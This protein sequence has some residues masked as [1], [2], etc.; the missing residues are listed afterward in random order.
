[1]AHQFS[2]CVSGAILISFFSFSVSLSAPH[3]LIP[4]PAYAIA[5][6]AEQLT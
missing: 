4:Y 1:V 6:G 2:F 3:G 5:A